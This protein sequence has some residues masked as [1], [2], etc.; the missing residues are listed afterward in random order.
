MES[1]IG[2]NLMNTPHL[3]QTVRDRSGDNVSAR[4]QVFSVVNETASMKQTQNPT[5]GQSLK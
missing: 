4:V 2:V 5:T 1:Q 3:F